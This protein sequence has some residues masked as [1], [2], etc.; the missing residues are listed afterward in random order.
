VNVYAYSMQ[1]GRI[2]FLC[3]ARLFWNLSLPVLPLVFAL[4]LP[5]SAMADEKEP[6]AFHYWHMWTDKNGVSHMGVLKCMTSRWRA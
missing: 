5:W 4:I 6:P 1:S 2:E 3:A